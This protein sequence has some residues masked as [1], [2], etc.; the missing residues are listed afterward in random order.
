M[1]TIQN[2]K[3]EKNR[4]HSKEDYDKADKLGKMITERFMRHLFPDVVAIHCP[5]KLWKRP[6][7]DYKLY[8][9]VYYS[10][11]MGGYFIAESEVKLKYWYRDN[12]RYDP[13]SIVGR[14]FKKDSLNISDTYFSI[15]KCG[16]YIGFC[17]FDVLKKYVVPYCKDTIKDG[18]VSKDELFGYLDQKYIMWIDNPTPGF[19]KVRKATRT[20][21]VMINGIKC[22][23][24]KWDDHKYD[25]ENIRS[26][27]KSIAKKGNIIK[28]YYLDLLPHLTEP[29]VFNIKTCNKLKIMYLEDMEDAGL[30]SYLN[31]YTK[32]CEGKNMEVCLTDTGKYVLDNIEKFR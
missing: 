3:G 13:F 21:S 7:Y 30:I 17:P 29:K 4:P 5:E 20:K 32:G 6:Y 24:L 23:I 22:Y 28:H 11:E 12:F 19:Y 27:F 1:T 26:Y 10:E 18:I 14:K 16:K 15:S 2:C 31:D 9:T 8:D 25:L